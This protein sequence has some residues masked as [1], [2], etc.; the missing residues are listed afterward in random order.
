[1]AILKKFLGVANFCVPKL[2]TVKLTP[3]GGTVNPQVTEET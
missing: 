3:G 2:P 1:M